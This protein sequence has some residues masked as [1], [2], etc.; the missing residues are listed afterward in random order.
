MDMSKNNV[1]KDRSA[2]HEREFESQVRTRV[3]RAP[4][5][6]LP[7]FFYLPLHPGGKKKISARWLYL[8]TVQVGQKSLLLTHFFLKSR[9]ILME[10]HQSSGL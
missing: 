10:I 3:D 2:G 8:L 5:P 6:T 7:K 4:L 9:N 1:L